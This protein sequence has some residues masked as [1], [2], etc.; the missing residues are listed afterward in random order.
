MR[1][2]SCTVLSAGLFVSAVQSATFDVNSAVDAVDALPGDG[3]CATIAGAC[4]L[5]AAVMEA[6]AHSAADEIVL[7]AGSFE[8]TLA[9][10]GDDDSLSGD[11]DVRASLVLRGAGPTL[12]TIDGVAMDRV[13]DLHAPTET[14]SVV[15]EGLALSN[16]RLTQVLTVSAGTGL[17]VA[18]NVVVQLLDVDIRDNE[19]GSAFGGA[20]GID[21]RGCL[22]GLR[23]RILRNRDPADVGSGRALAGGVTTRGPSSCFTLI[24]SEISENRGDNAG[25]IYTDDFAPITLTR[26]LVS[27]NSARVAGALLLNNRNEVLLEDTTLS[28]NR[29]NYGAVLNDGGARLTLRNCTITGNGGSN[30]MATV[31]ALQD[32]HGGF[33][34][35]F[36]SNTIVAGNGPG[37]AADDCSNVTSAGGGNLI[38]SIAGCTASLLASD[39]VG[40]DPGLGVLADNGGLTRTHLPGAPARD[41]GV[42]AA[43]SAIDQ[44]GVTRP[45]DGNGDGV[46]RCDVGAVEFTEAQFLDGFE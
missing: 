8:L 43:C 29:G 46:A 3:N 4:S 26:S 10:T 15:V 42:D 38:G 7:P 16:G 19:A 27:G 37:F 9:G 41:F 11:L 12:T 32:V 28:G 45:R 2:V 31:G 20:V 30:A 23:V 33:G 35:I 13:L 39:R 36:L 24:D 21:N 25:A 6:N 34:L 14:L 5:R 44:R 40:I 1:V 22:G 18:Q 17:R